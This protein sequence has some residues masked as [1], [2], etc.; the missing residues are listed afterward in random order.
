M[1]FRAAAVLP[2]LVARTLGAQTAVLY[3]SVT[4]SGGAPLEYVRVQVTGTPLTD[5]TRPDGRYRIA[6]VSPG[7]L[8]VRAS[9]VGF[10]PVLQTVTIRPGDSVALNVALRASALFQ[11]PVIGQALPVSRSGGHECHRRDRFRSRPARGHR[12]R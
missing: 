8:V 1:R 3:G 5:L 2:L 11:D 6:G 10:L 4:D 7:V 9:R 12:G